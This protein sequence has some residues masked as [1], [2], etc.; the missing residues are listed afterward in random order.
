MTQALAIS[1]QMATMEAVEERFHLTYGIDAQFFTE[2]HEPLP[3]LSESEQ[4]ALAH[5]QK[6]FLEH[7]HRGFLPEGTVDKLMVSPLLDLAGLYEP[8]FTIRTEAT[9]DILLQEQ[10]ERLQGRID[11]LIVQDQL[12]V[13]VVEAKN[14][15]LSLAVAI[16]QALT[17]MMSAP[18]LN[19]PVYGLA[20]NGDE[21]RFIK[22]DK[23]IP[24]KPQFDLSDICSLFPPQRSKLEQVLRI[25]KQTDSLLA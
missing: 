15:S 25:L 18:H 12:W 6:R 11:T 9:V 3:V 23:S 20:T 22:L 16:P 10:G 4:I 14:T 17:Y 5:V 7:R 24:N 8:R 2:W 21:F 13:S 1:K 19:R